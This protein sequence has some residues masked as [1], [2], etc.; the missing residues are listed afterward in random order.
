MT[1]D[2][3]CGGAPNVDP[4]PRNFAVKG[5][6]PAPLDCADVS[7]SGTNAP[8]PLPKIWQDGRNEVFLPTRRSTSACQCRSKRRA[9]L[10]AVVGSDLSDIQASGDSPACDRASDYWEGAKRSD[11]IMH[12]WVHSMYRLVRQR[13][14]PVQV[15]LYLPISIFDGNDQ[16][17]GSR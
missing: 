17:C 16:R 13:V 12:G 4:Q 3:R 11:S 15:R 8:R 10:F 9:M 7:V 5:C 14:C 2:A 1:A 6:E